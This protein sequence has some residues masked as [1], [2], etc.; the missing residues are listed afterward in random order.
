MSYLVLEDSC[1]VVTQLLD[2]HRSFLRVR[3]VKGVG[4]GADTAVWSPVPFRVP[5]SSVVGP[6]LYILGTAGLTQVLIAVYTP[7]LFTLGQF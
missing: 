6:R 3:P 1:G 5:Q 2:W 4:G 7:R